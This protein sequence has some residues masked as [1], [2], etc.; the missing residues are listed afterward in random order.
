MKLEQHRNQSVKQPPTIGILY[1]GELGSAI[2]ALLNDGGHHVV[3]T[4]VG[5]SARTCTLCR[6]AGLETLPS[7][8]DVVRAADVTFSFVTPKS[9]LPV[10]E[11]FCH[12]SRRTGRRSLYVDAN[13]VS[14]ITAAEIGEMLDRLGLSFVD[15]SVHGLAANLKSHGTIYLSGAQAE[16]VGPIFE[17]W[18]RT[19]IL[20]D[21]VGAASQHKMLMGGLTKGLVALYLELSLVAR[22]A[23]LL[24][25]LHDCY[26]HYYPGIMT[27]LDR[28]LPTYAVHAGR[29]GDELTEVERT[30][31]SLGLEPRMIRSARRL[32]TALGEVDFGNP[33]ADG[34]T[35][36]AVLERAYAAGLL[37]PPEADA[38]ASNTPSAVCSASPS[39]GYA[40][41][42]SIISTP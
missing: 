34:F 38:T 26:R 33:P 19:R 18:L 24:E 16:E 20:G 25:Q 4:T 42:H 32:I 22:D 21:Q 3:T 36:A 8:D 2:G 23:G 6:N 39:V 29:R 1:P 5:R 17:P 15:A 10:A 13:S 31:R 7:V 28:L 9:A 30:I 27:V 35:P 40:A 37:D 12:A 11:E 41:D 14:P